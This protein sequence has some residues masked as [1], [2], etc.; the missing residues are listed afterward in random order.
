M[1]NI[2]E[3]VVH[4]GAVSQHDM[5]KILRS[6][7]NNH[8]KRLTTPPN[9][10][11]PLGGGDTPHIAYHYII[12]P[13]ETRSARSLAIEGYHASNYKVNLE[14]IGICLSGNFDV[15]KPTDSQVSQLHDLIRKLK[16]EFPDIKKVTGHR[17]YAAKSCPGR[18]FTD[19]MI[20]ECNDVLLSRNQE[21]PEWK[22]KAMLWGM[23]EGITN[24][25]DPLAPLDK[26][27]MIELLRKFKQTI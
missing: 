22:E 15:E 4:H 26:A 13:D 8:K 17:N 9:I 24:G 2:N 25:T 3:I 16:Q 7:D 12:T 20:A 5:S 1:R 14:S 18:N 11:Q 23:E 19:A 10:R 21:L 27:T 6:F